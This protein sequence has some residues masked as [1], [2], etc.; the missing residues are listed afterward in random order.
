MAPESMSADKVDERS[1]VWSF[2]VILWECITGLVPWAECSSVMQVGMTGACKTT[3]Q[4]LIGLIEH[5]VK[6]PILNTR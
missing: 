6:H 4:C 5:A 2:G 3:Y 1:D